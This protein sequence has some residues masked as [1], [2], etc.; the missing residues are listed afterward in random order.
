MKSGIIVVLFLLAFSQ[1]CPRGPPGIH[2]IPGPESEQRGDILDYISFVFIMLSL[3]V[4][5]GLLSNY[6][7]ETGDLVSAYF[8]QIILFKLV[9][10]HA[11]DIMRFC[12][13]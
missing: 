13:N 10:D 4:I 1:C 12:T 2:G 11:G 9:L 5:F 7:D 6:F 3:A 8:V